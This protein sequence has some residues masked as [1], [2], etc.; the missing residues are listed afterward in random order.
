MSGSG[1]VLCAHRFHSGV[2]TW[3]RRRRVV[4]PRL[5]VGDIVQ[6]T[7]TVLLLE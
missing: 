1:A 3:S 7:A 5:H 6:G 4:P 2:L